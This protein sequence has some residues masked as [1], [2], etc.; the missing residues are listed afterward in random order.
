M[1]KNKVALISQEGEKI[2]YGEILGFCNEFNAVFEDRR[3]LLI[4]C[5]ICIEVIMAYVAAI[6]NQIPVMLIE[7]NVDSLKVVDN[8]QPE[9]IWQSNKLESVDG[10]KVIW[11]NRKYSL[12]KR[13]NAVSYEINDELAL[14]LSTSGSTGSVK[15]VRISYENIECST[16]AIADSLNIRSED[17]A[18]AM[19]P[20]SYVYGLSII[21]TYLY[22][23][24]TLL[25]PSVSMIHRDFWDFFNEN[26]GTSIFGVPYTFEIIKKLNIFGK[27]LL[28]LKLAA[29]AGGK[30]TRDNEEYMV[31]MSLKYK[32]DF[33][34]MYGQ[35][36][37]TGRISSGFVNRSIEKVGSA[38]KVLP[39][40][41]VEINNEEIVYYGNNVAMG[42]SNG[43][44]DLIKGDE[45]NGKLRT[46]DIGYVDQDGYL[47]IKGRLKRIAK[48]NGHRISLDEVENIISLRLKQVCACVEKEGKLC[49]I[50]ENGECNVDKTLVLEILQNTINLHKK[51]FEVKCIENI[52]RNNI[53]KIMYEEIL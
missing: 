53:G 40:G 35:T 8:Y 5:E 46:G 33:A 45:F 27:G 9:Y 51:C 31:S 11:N 20:L 38:G 48:I 19:L 52:P 32:F 14:L 42:Y 3:L 44:V 7:N 21:N 37:A 47:Y 2:T 23:G 12:L 29:V 4:K 26:G 16:K 10:Y 1:G 15:C 25:I 18:M 41:R 13:I 36:E 24:A 43:Y 28:N 39:I 17:I 34:S 22:K 6:R 30:I 50:F 49:V